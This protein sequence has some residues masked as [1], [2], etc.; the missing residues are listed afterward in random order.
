M[1]WVFGCLGD[2][3]HLKKSDMTM[4]ANVCPALPRRSLCTR[5]MVVVLDVILSL[6]DKITAIETATRRSFVSVPNNSADAAPKGGGRGISRPPA[7]MQNFLYLV[8]SFLKQE[9]CS[10]QLILVLR[11]Y[12]IIFVLQY[13]L[14][15]LSYTFPASALGGTKNRDT[16]TAK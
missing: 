1:K 13:L 15:A 4:F 6:P 11:P 12:P 10:K 16:R 3:A 9:T 8:P 2:R 5:A 14:S 7:P